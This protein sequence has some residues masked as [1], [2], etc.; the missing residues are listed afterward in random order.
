MK[1]CFTCCVTVL[2]DSCAHFI[3]RTG[4]AQVMHADVE[5]SEH[6]IR[7]HLR[8]AEDHGQNGTQQE[9]ESR[10]P[11]KE[12]PELSEDTGPSRR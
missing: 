11:R 9:A 4:C 10:V 3:C 5:P 8:Q 1:S 2:A 12:L 6:L 7:Q